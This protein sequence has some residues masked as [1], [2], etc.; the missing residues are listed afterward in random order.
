MC[1][2]D[3]LQCVK[4]INVID[5]QCIKGCEGLYVTSYFK[6][7]MNEETFSEFW[8]K[9]EDDY[10]KY[11]GRK[12]FDFPYE[13]RNFDWKDSY[14]IIGIYIDTPAFDKVTKD[15]AATKNDMFSSIG[16]TL[17]LLTGFSILSGV[18]ILYFLGKFL[19]SFGKRYT[20]KKGRM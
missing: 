5:G 11:K 13:L 19:L 20:I 8:S 17:G 14:K 6:T 9:V 15:V 18:E 10:K 1:K 7:K 16:G 12:D 4:K 3:K 2:P